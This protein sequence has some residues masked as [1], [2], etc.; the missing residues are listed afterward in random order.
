MKLFGMKKTK[1]NK[2]YKKNIVNS[3]YSNSF[4]KIL[5]IKSMTY[6]YK[7]KRKFKI[8]KNNIINNKT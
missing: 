1:N 8:D 2:L 5:K 4:Y 7:Q 6:Y 3:F